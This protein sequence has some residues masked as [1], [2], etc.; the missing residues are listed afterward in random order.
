MRVEQ[1]GAKKVNVAAWH[2]ELERLPNFVSLAARN[3]AVSLIFCPFCGEAEE[4]TEHLFV[5]C[6]LAQALWQVIT[7]WCK[8]FVFFAFMFRD[9]VE[10]HKFPVFPKKKAKA[11]HVV[12]LVTV[13]RL[14]KTRNALVH[15]GSPVQSDR[16]VD[17]IQVLGYL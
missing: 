9:I 4:T 17:D 13:W 12:V 11:L 15:E 14:W 5:S 7:Q 8:L 6:R 1:L 2:A 16:L 3:L 10:M